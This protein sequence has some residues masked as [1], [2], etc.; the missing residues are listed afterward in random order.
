VIFWPDQVETF[1]LTDLATLDAVSFGAEATQSVAVPVDPATLDNHLYLPLV[2]KDLVVD[3]TAGAASTM[4]VDMQP[5][6]VPVDPATLNSHIYLPLVARD[7][8]V[9][10]AAEA[11]ATLDEQAYLPAVVR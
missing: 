4:A 2:V 7:L 9:P 11:E 8:V 5:D 6:A 10:D 3:Q 1:G